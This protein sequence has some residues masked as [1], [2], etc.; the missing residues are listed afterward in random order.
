MKIAGVNPLAIEKLDKDLGS[1]GEIIRDEMG[2]P[3]GIFNERAQGLIADHIP[4]PS[5][6][7]NAQA[8]ELALASMFEKRHYQ[9]S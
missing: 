1:T 4:K 8:L 7:T 3:T 2:N 9:F 6:E 5:E